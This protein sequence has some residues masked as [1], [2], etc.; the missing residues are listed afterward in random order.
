M[1]LIVLIKGII[2]GLAV[3]IPVGPMGLL[4]VQRTLVNGR[5]SGFLSGLGAATADTILALVA[6][7][8]ISFIINFMQEKES[9]LH[10]LGGLMI[11]FIGFRIFNTNPVKKLR[12]MDKSRNTLAED[13]LSVLF[14]TLSNP[15][16]ILLFLAVFGGLK[17]TIS[18]TDHLQVFYL[19]SG[20]F[21]GAAS[22]WFLLSTV[23]HRFRN[24]LR[25][26]KLVWFNRI[27]GG[28]LFATGLFAIVTLLIR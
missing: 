24:H 18:Q 22:W 1:E 26:R 13:F 3:S 9:L 17:I 4:C 21:I 12:S 25:L 6:G 7:F 20:V 19:F 16:T 15:V 11:I 5:H 14:F 2:V 27:S 10:L 23:V 28:V 8:G